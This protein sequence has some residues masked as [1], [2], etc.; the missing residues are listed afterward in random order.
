MTY[1]QPYAVTQDTGNRPLAIN[2]REVIQFF[3]RKHRQN[4]NIVFLNPDNWDGKTTQVDNVRLV[5]HTR[6]AKN[7]YYAGLKN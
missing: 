7:Y 5:T 2:V 4:P 1:G 6:V 3:K